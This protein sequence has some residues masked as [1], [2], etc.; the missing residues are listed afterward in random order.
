MEKKWQLAEVALSHRPLPDDPLIERLVLFLATR[1]HIAALQTIESWAND[2]KYRQGHSADIFFSSD[3]VFK[4]LEFDQNPL[5]RSYALTI[6]NTYVSSAE[7]RFHPSCLNLSDIAGCISGLIKRDFD[8]GTSILR[9]VY[10][11]SSN[12]TPNEQRLIAHSVE[13]TDVGDKTLLK[14]MYSK[15]LGP[16]LFVE[17]EAN[18]LE[19]EVKFSDQYSRELLV[20][21]T[22]KL[23][24]AACFSQAFE[25]INL[26]SSDSD[27]RSD[28]STMEL[29]NSPSLH[30]QIVQGDDSMTVS[31]VRGWC[32]YALRGSAFKV[33]RN[34]SHMPS[35]LSLNL[36]PKRITTFELKP[37]SH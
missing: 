5:G 25:L 19:I 15:F 28:D 3:G 14:N 30:S 2:T 34:I 18:N 23:R 33:A 1:G 7:F 13:K 29:S 17:L 22:D 27:P 20:Q 12:L 24:V 26:F 9:R 32:A 21:F 4:L 31:T 36:R 10:H 11:S 6:L 35:R 16:I 37:L 8:F